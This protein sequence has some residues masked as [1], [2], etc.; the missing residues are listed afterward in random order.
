MKR[1][2][3]LGGTIY[4]ENTPIT[5]FKFVGGQLKELEVYSTDKKIIPFEFFDGVDAKSII[6]FF[7]ERITPETRQGLT[8]E[9]KKTPIQYY[10]EERLIRYCSGRCIHD[11]YWLDCDDDRTCWE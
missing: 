1:V 4:Y 3:N 6:K 8:E 10:H 9:L 11:K 7:D 2:G 5:K